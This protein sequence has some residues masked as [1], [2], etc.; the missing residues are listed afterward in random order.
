MSYPKTKDEWWDACLEERDKLRAIVERYAPNQV[1]LFDQYV[2][3]EDPTMADILAEV[4][5][6]APD[7][8]ELHNIPAWDT[9]C[10][11]CSER[12]VLGGSDE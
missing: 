4:W 8:P 6:E 7:V 9:L 3:T 5:W 12:G 1:V 10:D 11:L 2:E